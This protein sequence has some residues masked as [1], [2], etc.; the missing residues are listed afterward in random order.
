MNLSARLAFVALRLASW[1]SRRATM[2]PAAWKRWIAATAALHDAAAYD[3]LDDVADAGA[4]GTAL[5]RQLPPAL[6]SAF[7]DDGAG[8]GEA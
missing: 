8:M 2:P 7:G 1:L 4:L 3:R 5:D 6:Y